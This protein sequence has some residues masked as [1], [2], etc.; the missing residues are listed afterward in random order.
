MMLPLYTFPNNDI[1]KS[2]FVKN[3]RNYSVYKWVKFPQMAFFGG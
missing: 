1:I 2:K 3:Q